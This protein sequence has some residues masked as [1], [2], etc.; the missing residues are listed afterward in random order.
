M[1][2]CVNFHLD[3]IL[4]VEFAK[5]LA[6]GTGSVHGIDSSPAMIE[7]ARELCKDSK[8]ATFEGLKA[9]FVT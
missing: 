2:S 1:T 7:A 6:T 5:V 8:N 4:N 3:G 9:P